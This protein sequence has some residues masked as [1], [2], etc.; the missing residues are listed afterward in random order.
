MIYLLETPIF[1]EQIIYLC[2]YVLIKKPAQ[3]EA[4]IL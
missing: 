2:I 3:V 4:R 1:T